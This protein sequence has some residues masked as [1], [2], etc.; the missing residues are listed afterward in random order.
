MKRFKQF[1][2]LHYLLEINIH[3]K[4]E[5]IKN[6][7]IMVATKFFEFFFLDFFQIL[8]FIFC[9]RRKQ[10]HFKVFHCFV[11]NFQNYLGL[12]ATM[13]TLF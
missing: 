7:C 11:K 2:T 6:A 4:N 12:M 5:L 13:S 8:S 1:Y 9:F 10:T 3:Y